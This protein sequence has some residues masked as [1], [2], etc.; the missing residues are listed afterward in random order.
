MKELSLNILDI[1]Q[2]SIRAKAKLIEIKI[3]ESVKEDFLKI[4]I[5][6]DGTGISKE[7][8]KN[9]ADPY[10][11]SRTTRKVGMGLA[12]L[13]QHTELANGKIDIDSVEG[14]GTKIS[15][16]FRLNHIDRQP[17]GDIA[18]VMMILIMGNPG[19]EFIYFYSTDEG[20]FQM[21]TRE[22]KEIFEVNSLIDTD[23]MRDIKSMLSDN[24]NS[25]NAIA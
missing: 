20:D 22:I 10:V 9:V 17:M 7:M 13:K 12:F 25:I 18:G 2:N 14:K 6:D 1:V 21:D 16:F 11:T 23:L 5:S 8:L 3:M 24:M 19:I 4:E 15:A